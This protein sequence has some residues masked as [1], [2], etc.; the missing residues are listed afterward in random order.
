MSKKL[1]RNQPLD[2]AAIREKL[3]GARGRDYWRS[4]EEL[5]E[6]PQ[7]QHYLHN[8]FPRQ[9]RSCQARSTGAVRSS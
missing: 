1:E 8:E 3:S 6:T 9:S 4:L 7:F 5:A 2:L